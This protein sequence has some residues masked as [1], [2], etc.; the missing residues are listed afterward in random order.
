M[1]LQVLETTL[2]DARLFVPDVFGDERGYFKETYSTQKYHALGLDD[3]W[4][5][6]N[7][8]RSS[9]NVIRGLHG[10]NRMAKLVQVLNGRVWDVIADLRPESRTYR[11][12]EGFELSADNHRQLYIPA[13]FVHG[14]I[15]QSDD[16]V[17]CYKISALYDPKEEFAVNWRDPTLAIV[18]PLVGE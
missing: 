6:D 13:G 14:F 9:R 5:Q 15:A 11:K 17:F 16:V 10:D 7:V 12:W 2:Q 4:V 18:W 3:L 8:S 1:A